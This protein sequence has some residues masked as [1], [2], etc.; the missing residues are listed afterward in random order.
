MRRDAVDGRR[1][2]SGCDRTAISISR[3]VSDEAFY[4]VLSG[5][6]AEIAPPGPAAAAAGLSHRATG[7]LGRWQGLRVHHRAL[8][9]SRVRIRKRDAVHRE[10]KSVQF[11]RP[12][13]TAAA[14]LA[15]DGHAED[16]PGAAY[17]QQR[18]GFRARL[19]L[20]ATVGDCRG[21][22]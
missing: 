16:H 14:Q 6:S 22:V 19:D 9:G 13:R 3:E 11:G 12:A 4:E 2:A 7:A 8:A 18:V 17:R 15:A 10:R 1:P 21:G 5:A 20:L